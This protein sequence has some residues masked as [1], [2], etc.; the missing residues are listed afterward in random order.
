MDDVV[1]DDTCSTDFLH[2]EQETWRWV[3]HVLPQLRNKQV[4]WGTPYCSYSMK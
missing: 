4:S 2:D 1:C 3:Q